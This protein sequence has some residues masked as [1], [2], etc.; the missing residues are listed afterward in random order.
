MNEGRSNAPLRAGGFMRRGRL[1]NPLR[2]DRA[3][4]LT[5]FAHT[6]FPPSQSH[7]S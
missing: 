3:I 5:Q 1:R 7:F 6:G 4:F 2:L